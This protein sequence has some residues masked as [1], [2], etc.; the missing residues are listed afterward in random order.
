MTDEAR[1]KIIGALD[2]ARLYAQ[3]LEGSH[4]AE[5]FMAHCP[6]LDDCD[7]VQNRCIEARALLAAEDKPQTLDEIAQAQGIN[8]PQKMDDLL[9]AVPDLDLPD[10]AVD[11]PSVPMAM[12]EEIGKKIDWTRWHSAN[13]GDA[14][15]I[16]ARYG[17][18]ISKED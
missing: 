12:L 15:A 16:V 1:A 11:T 3:S 8:A 5:K 17:Y 2:D 9:G 10:D 14:S 7:R 13:V 6:T 18:T 4:I